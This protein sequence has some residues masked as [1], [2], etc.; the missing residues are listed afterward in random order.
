V[1]RRNRLIL[2]RLEESYR[3][4]ARTGSQ[5]CA[6]R[7]S[8]FSTGTSRH[9]RNC[10]WKLTAPNSSGSMRTGPDLRTVAADQGYDCAS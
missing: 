9:P 10:A 7:S 2:F 6:P 1:R 8:D 3:G 4:P 5:A